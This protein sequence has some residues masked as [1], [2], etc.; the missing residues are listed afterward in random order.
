MP[1]DAAMAK[2]G[3]GTSIIQALAGPLRAH[4][5]VSEASPGTMVSVAHT[6]IAAVQTASAMT[7]DR[8]V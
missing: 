3:L 4:I 8:A 6:Q 2:P 5:K 7:I 1:T